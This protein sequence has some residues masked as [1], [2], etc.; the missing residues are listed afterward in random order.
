MLYEIK[1]NQEKATDENMGIR[2]GYKG[3]ELLKVG[4]LTYFFLGN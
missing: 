3:L 4:Q 2:I 1:E